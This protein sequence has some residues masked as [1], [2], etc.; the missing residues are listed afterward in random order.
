M[1]ANEQITL[2]D[3]LAAINHAL[4]NWYPLEQD[5]ASEE[6]RNARHVRLFRFRDRLAK[7]IADNES[8]ER[9]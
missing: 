2:A 5:G 8:M 1:T 6:E 4:N 7:Q 9:K 3:C